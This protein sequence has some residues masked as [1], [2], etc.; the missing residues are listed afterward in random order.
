MLSFYGNGA[1]ADDS[2]GEQLWEKGEGK[3]AIQQILVS[4]GINYTKNE[5]TGQ[6]S[7]A[8]GIGSTASGIQSFAQGWHSVAS[9]QFSHAEG[10]L[11]QATGNSGAH[12]EGQSSKA[13]GSYSHAE[14]G[15]TLA[16]GQCSHAEGAATTASGKASHAENSKTLASGQFSHAQNQYTIAASTAQTA[17]GKFNIEDNQ[18]QHAVILGNGNSTASRSNAAFIDWNGNTSI[19][20]SLTLNMNSTNSATLTADMVNQMGSTLPVVIVEESPGE[21][22]HFYYN[23]NE[24]SWQNLADIGYILKTNVDFSSYGYPRGVY[25]TNYS[26]IE[27]TGQ[28]N[29]YFLYL[30]SFTNGFIIFNRVK[31]T[32]NNETATVASP[33]SEDKIQVAF[34]AYV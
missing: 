22:T 1:A 17:L 23:D 16:S 31:F 14:G 11:T 6:Q 27:E 9:G 28:Y 19:A 12:A 10:C 15:N 18:D 3:G 20:G 2:A 30:D 26:C 29:L 24:L 34:G 8:G 7:I 5:A 25:I 21:S 33:R 32:F 13:Y 4:T